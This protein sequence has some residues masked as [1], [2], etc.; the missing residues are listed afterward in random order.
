[1]SMRV[2]STM[3]RKGI[4]RHIGPVFGLIA[5]GLALGGCSEKRD[6]PTGPSTHPAAWM[7]IDSKDYHGARVNARGAVSCLACHTVTAHAQAAPEEV[8][9]SCAASGCHGVAGDP[10]QLDCATCHAYLPPSHASH[11]GG[12]FDNCVHCHAN[13]VTHAGALV[14]S[15]HMDG[16]VQDIVFE[17]RIGGAYDVNMMTCANTWCHGPRNDVISPAWSTQ[18]DL[19]CQSCHPAEKLSGAHNAPNTPHVGFGCA[20]CHSTVLSNDTTIS[21]PAL[22]INKEVDV[23]VNLGAMAYDALTQTCSGGYCHV[24]PSPNWFTFE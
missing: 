13:V 3:R 6:T 7:Q 21:N 24:D 9:L 12:G 8:A 23:A 18:A 11:T 22:H 2:R 4:M 5:L 14:D 17:E 10:N 16:T 19:T 1:M 20:R 15:L